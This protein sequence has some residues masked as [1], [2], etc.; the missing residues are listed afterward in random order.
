VA[1]TGREGQKGL[2]DEALSRDDR[3]LYAIDPDAAAVLGWAV[4]RA[5]ELTPIGSFDG[6]PATV[7]GLA[8]S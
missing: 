4:G 7:A 8:A 5:G 3:F 2:R 6:L 1:A